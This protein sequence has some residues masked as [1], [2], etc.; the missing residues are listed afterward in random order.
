VL[1]LA[2][3]AAA[4]AADEPLPERCVAI[5]VDDAYRTVYSEA[6]P[7]LAARRWP[8]T[9]FVNTDAVDAGR[10]PY[11]D[12]ERLRE[13]ARGGAAIESHGASH[14]HLIRRA[15]GE[16]AA[17]WLE[18]VRDDI[19]AAGRRIADEIGTPPRLF[20]YPYGEFNPALKDLVRELGLVGF[21]QHSGPAWAGGDLGAL[22]RFPMSGPYGGM[23]GFE[24]KVR[25]LPLPLRRAEP[26]DPVVPLEEWRPVLTLVMAPGSYRR[27]D[28]R[29][30]VNGSPDVTVRWRDEDP[31]VAE[32]TPGLDLAVGRNRYNCTMPAGEPGVYH[33][34]SHNW[35]RRHP[36][37]RWYAEP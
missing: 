22:P 32:V 37:G 30:F 6:Y 5:T 15:P 3:V 8:F 14:A 28:L 33:W 27:Q 34:Y 7:R 11:L 4:L 16:D 31:P 25:T 1:P 23:A 13:M 21:G 20:A 36:D 2:R 9:V 26:A 19:V 29:C 18:R 12:W 10:A 17:A 35:F 24:T